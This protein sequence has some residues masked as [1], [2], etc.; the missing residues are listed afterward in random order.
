VKKYSE[1]LEQSDDYMTELM[2]LLM[3]DYRFLESDFLLDRSSLVDGFHYRNQSTEVFVRSLPGKDGGAWVGIDRAWDPYMER[4]F[5]IPIW[6]VMNV[7]R[8]TCL[9]NDSNCSID[10]FPLYAI[11]LRECC[12]DM[13]TG[14]F[15]NVD[16]VIAWLSRREAD[17]EAWFARLLGDSNKRPKLP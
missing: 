3:D 2:S 4:G 11:A 13:L 7:R 10:K 1:I 17:R 9:Y 16:P 15:S 5:G 12:E 8:S 14:D 6:A